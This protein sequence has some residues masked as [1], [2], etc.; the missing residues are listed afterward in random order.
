MKSGCDDA[1]MYV[2]E[3]NEDAEPNQKWSFKHNRLMNSCKVGKNYYVFSGP[4]DSKIQ[5]TWK[6]SHVK[7]TKY[8]QIKF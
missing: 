2:V 3:Q 6:L 7:N 5:M 8:F 1:N 4:Q